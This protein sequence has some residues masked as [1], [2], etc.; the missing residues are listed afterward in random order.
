MLG[1]TKALIKKGRETR[2]ET[3]PRQRREVTSAMI[4]E[5]MSELF[6]TERQ[7]THDLKKRSQPLSVQDQRRDVPVA[8]FGWKLV[9]ESRQEV[10][11]T[12]ANGGKGTHGGN[13]DNSAGV[14]RNVVAAG[15][16]NVSNHVEEYSK[17]VRLGATEDV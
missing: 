14:G 15:D 1:A 3:S 11:K 5:G 2:F 13:D 12:L 7:A 10:R 17:R 8:E 9:P 16:D 6:A 4:C